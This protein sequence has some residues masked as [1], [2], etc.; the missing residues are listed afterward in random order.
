MDKIIREHQALS[1]INQ[2]MNNYGM[3]QM[4]EDST[5]NNK[6]I[7]KSGDTEIPGRR[8]I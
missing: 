7:L 4:Y 3:S 6:N 8:M 1:R 5:K 2:N